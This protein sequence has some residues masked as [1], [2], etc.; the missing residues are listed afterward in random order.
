MVHSIPG[1]DLARDRWRVDVGGHLDLDEGLDKLAPGFNC[2]LSNDAVLHEALDAASH[3]AF[4]GAEFLC[5]F[6]KGGPPV[7]SKQ[8]HETHVGFV[9]AAPWPW[10]S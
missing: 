1:T 7:A 8:L 6:R 2:E 9:H 10:G 4:T 3:G 5:Q